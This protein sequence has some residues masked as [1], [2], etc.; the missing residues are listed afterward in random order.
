MLLAQR[1]AELVER[2]ELLDSYCVM[3]PMHVR[4]VVGCSHVVWLVDEG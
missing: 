3:T 4:H 2:Q 1:M